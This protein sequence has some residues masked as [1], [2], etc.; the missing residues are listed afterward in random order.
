[1]VCIIVENEADIA[2][3][4]SFVDDAAAPAPAAPKPAAPAAPVASSPPPPAAASFAQP[5]GSK[6]RVYASPLARRL[7]ADKGLAIEVSF[8]LF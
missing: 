8:Y 4:K 1:M 7:A 6:D 2:A 3:F 5:T